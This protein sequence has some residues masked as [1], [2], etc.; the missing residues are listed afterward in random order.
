MQVSVTNKE[1]YLLRL[2]TPPC[3]CLREFLTRSYAY[4]SATSSRIVIVERS[5]KY[6]EC[7]P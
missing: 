7:A 2:L 5:L 4:V 1:W 6:G 3:Q